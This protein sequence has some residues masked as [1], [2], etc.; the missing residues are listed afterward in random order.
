MPLPDGCHLEGNELV[1]YELANEETLANEEGLYEHTC[2]VACTNAL[3]PLGGTT[4]KR[5]DYPE[6]ELTEAL[7]WG[8]RLL[9][10]EAIALY[11]EQGYLMCQ[12]RLPVAPM[13][14]PVP[15]GA[16]ERPADHPA[17]S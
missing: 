9:T 17:T 10:G 16:P 5:F 2:F 4:V 12:L 6:I 8:G 11:R 14:G 3:R 15:E 7:D 1:F 13:G